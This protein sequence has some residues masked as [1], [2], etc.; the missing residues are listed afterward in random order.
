MRAN[1][2]RRSAASSGVMA[3]DDVAFMVKS[4][5][6]GFQGLA[7]DRFGIVSWRCRILDESRNLGRLVTQLLQGHAGLG[8][9]IFRCGAALTC[10]KRS[11]G[12]AIDTVAQLDDDALGGLLA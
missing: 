9:W 8:Q 4:A 11:K 7:D 6:C 1:A 10:S 12:D 5:Q 3:I 2:W